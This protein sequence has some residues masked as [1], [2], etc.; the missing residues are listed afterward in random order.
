[1]SFFNFLIYFLLISL[2]SCKPSPKIGDFVDG[3]AMTVDNRKLNLL[4]F[5]T[6]GSLSKFYNEVSKEFGIPIND[7]VYSVY[8]F[9]NEKFLQDSAVLKIEESIV[10]DTVESKHVFITAETTTRK[11]LL[12][13]GTQTRERLEKY[14]Y[15]LYRK[16]L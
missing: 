4:S 5:S 10:S 7:S 3:Y 8:H 16:N 15:S 12:I 14:F 6:T 1:M 9:Q 13:P 11:D 2:L